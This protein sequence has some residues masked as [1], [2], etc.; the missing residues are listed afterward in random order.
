MVLD[1]RAQGYEA[2]ALPRFDCLRKCVLKVTHREA[3]N[4]NGSSLLT[5]IALTKQRLDDLMTITLIS[6]A[7][8]IE[9][10][11]I[12]QCLERW[13]WAYVEQEYMRS[14]NGFNGKRVVG[15]SVT[16]W[17]WGYQAGIPRSFIFSIIQNDQNASYMCDISFIFDRCHRSWAQCSGGRN[18]SVNDFT[19]RHCRRITDV[20]HS[21]AANIRTFTLV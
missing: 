9:Y 18:M 15:E 10:R 7:I 12:L 21:D 8:H 20:R 14:I 16:I 19:Q 13:I 2:E 17:G 5:S 11:L 3:I 4:P 6:C 1:K